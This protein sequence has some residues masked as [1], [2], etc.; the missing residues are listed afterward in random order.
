MAKEKLDNANLR[1]L[2]TKPTTLK[3]KARLPHLFDDDNVESDSTLDPITHNVMDAVELLRVDFNKLYDDVHHIYKMLFNAFGTAES[4]NWDSV[5]PTGP[6]GNIGPVGPTGSAGAKGDTGSQGIAGP[7]VQQDQKETQVL[8]VQQVLKVLLVVL[9]QQ[10]ERVLLEV[11]VLQVLPDQ[12]EA[13]V[14]QVLLE[15][16]VL[17][18]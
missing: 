1:E 18:G 9:V 11:P 12:L 2:T 8:K 16:Q 10:V 14:P 4:E 5:G 15:A 13:L 7:R 3:S 6:Q 17:K